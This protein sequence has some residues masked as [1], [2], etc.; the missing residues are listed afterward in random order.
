MFRPAIGPLAGIVI[1]AAIAILASPASGWEIDETATVTRVIDGDT[2]D[3]SPTGRVR[4]A[5]VD[6]PEYDETGYAEAKE[7]LEGLVGGETVYLDV[8]DLYG[9]DPYGRFVAVAYVVYD[10]TRLLNVNQALLDAG[11]A[12]VAD[13]AN[14]FDPYAWAAYVAYPPPPP[15]PAPLAASASAN[16]GHGTAPLAVAFTATASGGVPPY[17]YRWEFGDGGTSTLQN[18]THTYASAGTYSAQLTVTDSE[19][20]AVTRT[21]SVTV[22]APDLPASGDEAGSPVAIV[23]V[24]VGIAVLGAAGSAILLRSRRVRGRPPAG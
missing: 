19:G 15:P 13:Y 17:T 22:T 1:L 23:A 20:Q 7:F 4:L 3:A 5:D 14:E 12:D 9:T 18:P 24:V 2:F 11:L 8:D 21:A 10:A 6:A 16:P